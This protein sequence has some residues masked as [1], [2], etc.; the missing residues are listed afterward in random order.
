[1][2][3]QTLSELWRVS[4]GVTVIMQLALLRWRWSGWAQ[5]DK[6]SVLPGFQGDQAI[7]QAEE[8]QKKCRHSSELLSINSYKRQGG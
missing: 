1:M 5:L 4:W 8:V 3:V 6:Q 7:D 2:E